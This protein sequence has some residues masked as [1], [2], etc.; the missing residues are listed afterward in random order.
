M[1]ERQD[2]NG[3]VKNGDKDI[4]VQEALQQENRGDGGGPLHYRGAS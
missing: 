4:V 1:Q 2:Q 3:S